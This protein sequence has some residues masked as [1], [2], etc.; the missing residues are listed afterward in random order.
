MP[1]CIVL[2]AVFYDYFNIAAQQRQKP[3]QTINGETGKLAAHQVGDPGLIN[4]QQI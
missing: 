4:P 1:G 2:R 3:E